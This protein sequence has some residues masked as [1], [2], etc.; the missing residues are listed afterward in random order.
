M[1]TGLSEAELIEA[2]PGYDALI[3]RSGTTVTD[4]LLEAGTRLEVVGRAGVGIDNVDI[5]SATRRGVIVMNTPSANTVATAEHTMALLLATSRHIGAAHGS[6]RAATGRRSSFAGQEMHGKTLGIIGFGRV[7]KL[8]ASRAQAFGM[9]VLAY[10]PYVSEAV[11]REARVMLANLDEVLGGSDYVTLHTALSA[12]TDNL[13]NAERLAMMRD[14]S[15][16]INAA[17]GGFGGSKPWRMRST[18]A[19]SRA[20]GLDV[21]PVSRLLPTTP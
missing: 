2:I 10:D 21:F 5:D 1:R 4:A 9:E 15:I 16:L 20:V 18:A 19:S 14:G 8:V 12:E 13:I 11:A 3:I 7:G 6:W 17:R